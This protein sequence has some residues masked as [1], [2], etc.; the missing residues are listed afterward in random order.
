MP[1]TQDDNADVIR[2]RHLEAR[3]R[4]SSIE[5]SAASDAINRQLLR[6]RLFAASKTIGVYLATDDEVDLDGFIS[7]AWARGKQLY[8]P[9]ILRKNKMFFAELLPETRLVSNRFGIWEPD[10]SDGLSANQLDWILV[11]MVAFDSELHRI[12]MGG[13]YYDRALAFTKHHHPVLKPR[14]SGVAFACQQTPKISANP[15]DIG[16]S[17]VYTE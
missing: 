5:R 6:S 4:M 1:D 12:G 11:P 16:V 3:R 2:R 17:R 13:G 15:W 9:R 10:S 7:A 14:L 8:A